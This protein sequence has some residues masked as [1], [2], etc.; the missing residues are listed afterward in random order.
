ML[1]RIQ[2]FFIVMFIAAAGICQQVN[3]DPAFLI[4]GSGF[5]N[6]RSIEPELEGKT[7]LFD[8]FKS[9]TIHFRPKDKPES[10]MGLLNYDIYTNRVLI[11]LNGNTLELDGNRVDSVQFQ[12]EK[13]SLLCMLNSK[14][15]MGIQQ[16]GFAFDLHD[17]LRFR[18]VKLFVLEVIKPTYNE[19]MNVGSRNYIIKPSHRYFIRTKDA[20]IFE[21]FSMRKASFLEI[22]KEKKY[23]KLIRASDLE[24]DSDI[25]RL[26]T[27]MER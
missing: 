11:L 18:L 1:F 12:V 4:T 6:T 16:R 13:D 24:K 27:L 15:L 8:V 22:D 2:V 14:F 9:G 21:R 3:R 20:N 17:G 10:Y 7:T 5:L 23:Q 25:A 26:M 19:L